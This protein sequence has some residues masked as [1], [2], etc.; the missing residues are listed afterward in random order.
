[1]LYLKYIKIILISDMDC[2]ELH[3]NSFKGFILRLFF[4]YLDF[5][6]HPQIPDFQIVVSQLICPILINHTSM[7][8]LFI[9]LS[10][11]V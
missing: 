4:Q 3:L 7:E 9:Q 2:Q 6:L 5:F 8:S 10:D 1:M 11:D